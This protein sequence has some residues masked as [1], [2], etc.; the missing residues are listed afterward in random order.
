MTKLFLL[1][2]I[3]LYFTNI[4]E[5]IKINNFIGK[6]NSIIFNKSELNYNNNTSNCT[7]MTIDLDKIKYNNNKIKG[8]IFYNGNCKKYENQ[9]I[10]CS[11]SNNISININESYK[12]SINCNGND[13]D[14][15]NNELLFFICE[16]ID[17]NEICSSYLFLYF[18][19][20]ERILISILITIIIIIIIIIIVCLFTKNLCKRCNGSIQNATNNKYRRFL[21]E[22]Y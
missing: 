13:I 19:D 9:I 17:N 15:D 4:I 1:F 22:N 18:N 21:E 6:T 5:C 11:L 3:F 12:Y 16:Y 7:E 8:T 14:I 2:F 20:I 10:Y